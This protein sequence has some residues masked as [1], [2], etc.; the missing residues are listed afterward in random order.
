MDNFQP[1]NLIE[2]KVTHFPLSLNISATRQTALNQEST[3][4]ALQYTNL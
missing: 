3:D 2:P 1:N 4:F